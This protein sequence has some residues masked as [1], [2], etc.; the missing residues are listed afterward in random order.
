MTFFLQSR[1]FLFFFTLPVRT[2]AFQQFIDA[3]PHP[4][5]GIGQAAN[6]VLGVRMDRITEILANTHV[7]C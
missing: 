6:L 5:N 4:I 7:F 3:D 1:L 2:G